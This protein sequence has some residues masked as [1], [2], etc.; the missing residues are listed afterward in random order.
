VNANLYKSRPDG[1]RG[2]GAISFLRNSPLRSLFASFCLRWRLK[3]VLSPFSADIGHPH[4]SLLGPAPGH[5][6]GSKGN[7]T[8]P[9]SGSAE[10][11]APKPTRRFLNDARHAVKDCLWVSKT[12]NPLPMGLA[13]ANVADE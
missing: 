7:L 9:L 13:Q 6:C 1:C 10:L 5:H 2:A 11:R 4:G 3:R 12:R 8:I